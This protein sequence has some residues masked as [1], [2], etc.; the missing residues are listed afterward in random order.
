MIYRVLSYKDD[1]GR[2][3]DVARI[4]PSVKLGDLTR[5]A[6][7]V[8]D[9]LGK[10]IIV[11]RTDVADPSP[12]PRQV[13]R[14][15]PKRRATRKRNPKPK[16]SEPARALKTFRK[17]HQFDPKGIVRVKGSRSI[18]ARLVK[19]G[20]IPE[21]VYRSD[22]WSGK[23]QTYLHKTGNPRPLLCTDPDGKRLYIVGGNLRVTA[24]GITG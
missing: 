8:A 15:N 24:R 21:I 10:S 7:K 23:P 18:P 4:A 20:E 11:R 13:V 5:I 6:Q 3:V 14:R 16:V 9:Q 17:W 1:Q 22:K 2:L 19:L 12:R